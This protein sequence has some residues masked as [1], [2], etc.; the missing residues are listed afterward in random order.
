MIQ[1]LD[2]MTETYGENHIVIQ[3][4]NEAARANAWLRSDVRS[5]AARVQSDYRN[6]NV[7]GV[8]GGEVAVLQ[9]TIRVM[10]AQNREQSAE[11]SSLRRACREATRQS[12]LNHAETRAS[13]TEI[14]GFL[15]QHISA[16]KKNEV[17]ES[18]AIS[19]K[20]KFD[21]LDTNSEEVPSS[22]LS[23]SSSSSS[24]FSSSSTAPAATNM[25]NVLMHGSRVALS[26]Y[27]IESTKDLQASTVYYDYELRHLDDPSRGF[28]WLS[29]AGSKTVKTKSD[30]V[31]SVRS[32]VQYF[33]SILNEDEK[34][35]FASVRPTNGTALYTTWIVELKTITQAVVCRAFENLAVLDPPDKKG[36]GQNM[37][38]S[39][40][41]RRIAIYSKPQSLPNAPGEEVAH[42]DDST[43]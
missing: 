34:K 40:M 16:S 42:D 17:R 37:T 25:M 15:M 43:I 35:F 2:N 33:R 38:L 3:K 4:V 41:S 11:I 26:G 24:F 28:G 31:S 19:L 30:I 36:G 21:T 9:E 27:F 10:H 22:V 32:I 20:R 14:Q 8:V 6:E 39:A 13:L 18:G 5:W 12:E 7:M 29:T 23:S 1:D